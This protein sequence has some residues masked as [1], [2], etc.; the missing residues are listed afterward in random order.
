MKPNVAF[1]IVL[2]SFVAIRA[3]SQD[4][5]ATTQPARY[6]NPWSDAP[7][8]SPFQAIRWN[9]Q[10]PEVKVDNR[11]CQWLSLNDV[12]TDQ[13]VK[14]AQTADPRDW[15]K[16]IAEDLP[17]LLDM[18][19]HTPGPAVDLQIKDLQTGQVQTLPQVPMTEENRRAIHLALIGKTAQMTGQGFP[20]L[21]PFQA[22]HWQGQTPQVRV[23]GTWYKLLAFNDLS[24]DQLVALCKSMDSDRWQKRFEEDLIEVLQ[25]GGYQPGTTATL[26]VQELTTGEQKVLKNVPM[27]EANRRAILNAAQQSDPATRRPATAPTEG[28]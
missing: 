6:A 15:Q 8:V 23:D 14:F 10:T 26:K 13:I 1:L 9:Q 11:W 20:R 18:M 16:R 22:V 17:G 27:T 3:M 19:G 5:P 12:P 4:L 25:R 7:K 24:A 21:S 28:I 2:F